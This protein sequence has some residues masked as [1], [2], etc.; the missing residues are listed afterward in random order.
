MKA[1][2]S[3]NV[4]IGD[5]QTP[6]ERAFRMHCDSRT[7]RVSKAFGDMF[8]LVARVHQSEEGQAG[9]HAAPQ[10]TRRVVHVLESATYISNVPSVKSA[11][12]VSSNGITG[13]KSRRACQRSNLNAHLVCAPARIMGAA[14][15]DINRPPWPGS[16]SDKFVVLLARRSEFTWCNSSADFTHLDHRLAFLVKLGRPRA[17]HYWEDGSEIGP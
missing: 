3:A 10:E 14:A 4:T 16:E 7:Y 5:H 11:E 8:F 2:S 17:L 13:M 1:E 9:A 12:R 15:P 6:F